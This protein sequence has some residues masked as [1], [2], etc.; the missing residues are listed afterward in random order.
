VTPP[1]SG[2][3][4]CLLALADERDIRR[5]LSRIA[6]HNPCFWVYF[7]TDTTCSERIA[8]ILGDAIHLRHTADD[9]QE[10]ADTSRAEYI[11]I[12]GG[13]NAAFS[14]RRWW[15]TTVSEKN[16]FVTRLFLWIC[17]LRVFCR[18]IADNSV[19][20]LVVAE[21]H[22]L[23]N[24]CKKMAEKTGYESIIM[25]SSILRA[26]SRIRHAGSDYISLA[27]FVIGF[28]L[29]I[30]LART[31]RFVRG[32]TG[33]SPG[34]VHIIH[35]WTDQRSFSGG[36]YNNVYFHDLAPIIE[37]EG[38]TVVDLVQVL[39]TLPYLSAIRK[40]KGSA[41]TVL[42]FEECLRFRE[43]VV[44]AFSIWSYRPRIPAVVLSDGLEITP[45]VQAELAEGRFDTRSAQSY[46]AYC[47]GKGLARRNR[48]VS[49]IYTFE[50]HMWEKMFNLALREH[51][52]E[53]R[54]IGYVHSIVNRMYTCYSLGPKE[55]D[56]V[57]LPDVIAVNGKRAARVLASSGFDRCM[58]VVWGALRDFALY[59]TGKK[60]DVNAQKTVLVATSAGLGPSLE[61][62]RIALRS[63]HKETALSVII[64]FHPTIKV[65]RT[66]AMLPPLPPHFTVSEDP[67]SALLPVS[68][69]LLYTESTV[70]VEA[71]AQHIPLIHVKSSFSIDMNILEE[72][73]CI[74]S[75]SDPEAIRLAARQILSG[76]DPCGSRVES[77]VSDI[78]SGK[79]PAAILTSLG[80]EG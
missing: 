28:L 18:L 20:F 40:L 47:A 11:E 45:L 64:K 56:I 51:S 57:P 38:G 35:S 53:T 24:A 66:L 26:V 67:V 9:L 2:K 8:R 21:N 42:L 27:Y 12:I 74:P 17:Y 68:D 7:G 16:P 39:P 43:P 77:I 22:A 3:T 54:R 1:L 55:A 32:R 70:C 60:R 23:L 48:I 14:S 52:P 37:S 34:P 79:D 29:R 41:R 31:V 59:G 80:H 10:A 36:T 62:A 63:F 6:E 49:F 25:K 61:L 73:G 13:L 65:S 33:H 4:V 69:L 72:A 44:A 78:F 15:L 46:L 19:T 30:I 58:I 76:P 50:N 71:L 5:N 75:Y